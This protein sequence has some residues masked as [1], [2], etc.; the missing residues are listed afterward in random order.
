MPITVLIN[1]FV[2]VSDF[3]KNGI[4][5]TD[6]SLLLFV[7]FLYPVACSA[8]YLISILLNNNCTFTD[9]LYNKQMYEIYT[10]IFSF[11]R[12]KISSTEYEQNIQ[13]IDEI[14][15][16]SMDFQQFINENSNIVNTEVNNKEIPTLYYTNTLMK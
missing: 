12:Y 9:I 1:I 8:G 7:F 16:N 3:I 4:I 10:G 5:S 6:Y 2:K 11:I 15:Y 14:I 13:D